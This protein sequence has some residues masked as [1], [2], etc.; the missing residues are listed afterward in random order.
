MLPDKW[1]CYGE[2]TNGCLVY[3]LRSISLQM[4]SLHNLKPRSLGSLPFARQE[5]T[6]REGGEAQMEDFEVAKPQ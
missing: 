2:T 6:E 1:S 3:L 4:I 5:R